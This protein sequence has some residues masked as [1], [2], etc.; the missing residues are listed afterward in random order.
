MDIDVRGLASGIP[1]TVVD[2]LFGK[3]MVENS[4]EFKSMSHG[5][6]MLLDFMIRTY[7][8]SELNQFTRWGNDA[9][10]SNLDDED[11]SE[12]NVKG[13]RRTAKHSSVSEFSGSGKFE[14]REYAV[15]K[16]DRQDKAYRGTFV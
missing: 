7:C 8:N 10:L 1:E 4:D 14:E 3:D 16:G 13:L 9:S 11:I 2:F 6:K 15:R 12:E 5:S